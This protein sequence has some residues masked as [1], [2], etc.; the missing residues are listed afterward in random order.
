MGICVGK[1]FQKF[2]SIMVN[3]NKRALNVSWGNLNMVW[4]W[5]RVGNYC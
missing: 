4:K 2:D 5:G 1:C 3:K